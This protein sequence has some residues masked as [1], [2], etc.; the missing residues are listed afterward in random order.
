MPS[1][2]ISL[3]SSPKLV[4]NKSK[5]ILFPL[6]GIL[7]FLMFWHLSARQ[8]ET[9]LG[10]LPGPVQTYHQFSNLVN[11]H[12]QERDKEQAFIER[13]EKR[14]AA[15]LAKNPEAKVKIR[16]YTGK[17]TF[18]DQI[19]TSLITVAAGFLLAT[20]T[21]I[22]LGIMLGLNQ[23]LYQAFN[24]IIQLLKPVSPLAW[25]PIVTM[26]VSATYVSD[27]PLFAKSF[28]NSLLTVALCSLWPTL[29][30]TAVGVTSVDKDLIN[31]SKVLQL[32][33]WQHIRTIVL[34]SAIPM[35]FTGLRLSLGIAWMVL[36]AAEMLAQNPGLGK[37]VWDEFQN[38]S[39]ASLGRIMVAVITIG[40]IG[41]MLDRGMLQL[42]KWL[43][44]NKQQ[45]LR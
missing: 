31:V 11:E 26:V 29:I 32:S 41:L 2:V 15:K 5:L 27:D 7:M 19:I 44:W 1:N 8:V 12:W 37:F 4:A 40:F 30:N 28:I 18:F 22:P 13:Q 43:S 3:V 14:N 16:P 6:I 9:S 39:S 24:P 42:Q 23:G 21:A 34:P 33:W 25:L 35:I 38:G 10:T 45:A 17:P 36:I 20:L